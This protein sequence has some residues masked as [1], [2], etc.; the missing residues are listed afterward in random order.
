MSKGQFYL[1]EFWPKLQCCI[2]FY[3]ENCHVC[4]KGV[5]RKTSS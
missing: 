5:G 2:G 4:F 3:N 1:T